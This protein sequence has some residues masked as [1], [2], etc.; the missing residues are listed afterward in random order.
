LESRRTEIEAF[1][2]AQL[3]SL[4]VAW[5]FHGWWWQIVTRRHKGTVR[6]RLVRFGEAAL[7]MNVHLSGQAVAHRPV[8][9]LSLVPHPKKRRMTCID[10]VDDAHVGLVGVL[11]M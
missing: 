9:A 7:S 5:F 2:A 4:T 6:H 10:E 8:P 1:L 3:K 11:S